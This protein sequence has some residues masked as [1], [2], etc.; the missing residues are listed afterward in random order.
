MT[1]RNITGILLALFLLAGTLAQIAGAAPAGPVEIYYI[2]SYECLSCEQSWPLIE[3]AMN[4]AQA[5]VSLHKYDINSREGAA[6]ASARGISTVPAVVFDDGS[7]ILFEHYRDPEAFRAAFSE[8]L[9][10][11]ILHGMPLTIVR[12]ATESESRKGVV[13]VNTCITCSGDRPLKVEV[14]TGLP[15]GTTLIAGTEKWTG[16][17][18]PGESRQLSSTCE[19][20]PGTRTIPPMTVAYDDG[21]GMRSMVWPE[22]TVIRLQELSATAAYIAGLIAGIN[23]CLLAIMAFIGTTAISDT[24]HRKAVIVRIIAFCGGMLAVYLLI[25]VGLIELIE[26]VPAIDIVLHALIILLLICLSAWSFFDA[27]QTRRGKDSTA[28]RSVLDRIKP[29]YVRFG[30]A[31]SFAIGGAFG[32]IKMPCVG[33]I[34][35]AILGTIL[36]SGNAAQGIPL[37]I[38]YNL[39]VVTPVLLLGTLITAG[40]SPA[41]VNRFRLRHRIGLKIFTGALLGLMALAFLLGIM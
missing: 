1:W 37:L 4:E 39:G 22:T 33:G 32:L 2:Y 10:E 19:L 7:A 21:T 8:K 15:E 13:T 41:A 16:F 35:V 26:R 9:R 31:A 11:R 28:F 27:W 25:G 29:L 20:A 30:L 18:Q 17:L 36:E 12:N 34:Y 6:F 14:N 23:P 40:L 24:G 5:L 3:A 38:I